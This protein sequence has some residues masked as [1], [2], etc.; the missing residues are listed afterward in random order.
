MFTENWFTFL[1]E[2]FLRPKVGL[3]QSYIIWTT[4]SNGHRIKDKQGGRS[5]NL[6]HSALATVDR[7][8]SNFRAGS[9]SMNEYGYRLNCIVTNTTMKLKMINTAGLLRRLHRM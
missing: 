8:W 6:K 5:R 3:R 1:A 4:E 7:I 9:R 2:D